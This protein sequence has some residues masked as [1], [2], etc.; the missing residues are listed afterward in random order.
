[1]RRGT[2]DEVATDGFIPYP[3]EKLFGGV[4]DGGQVRKMTVQVWE[5]GKALLSVRRMGQAWKKWPS[6]IVKAMS[7]TRRQET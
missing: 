1:M 5:V 2:Q 6:M 3:G 7:N 4:S